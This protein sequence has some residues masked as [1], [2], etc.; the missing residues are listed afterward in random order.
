LALVLLGAPAVPAPEPLLP[1]LALVLLGAAAEP[2]PDPLL[3]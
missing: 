3:P 2:A 1:W